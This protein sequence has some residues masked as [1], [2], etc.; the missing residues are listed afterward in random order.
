MRLPILRGLPLTPRSSF[1]VPSLR[2]TRNEK[3]FST[4]FM[5]PSKEARTTLR[6]HP[7]FRA[8]QANGAGTARRTVPIIQRLS[9]YLFPK[10]EARP[11]QGG[12][13]RASAV[14]RI[15]NCQKGKRDL[16]SQGRG[17]NRGWL[18]ALTFEAFSLFQIRSPRR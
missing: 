1:E 10:K 15:L 7:G 13:N 3:C 14:L 16:T 12:S 5:I 8:L 4:Y 6:S 17:A 9:T 11:I 18:R 2:W